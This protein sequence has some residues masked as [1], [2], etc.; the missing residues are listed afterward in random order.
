MT[1]SGASAVIAALTRAGRTLAVAE[2]LTGGALTAELV[3]VPG[4][5]AV[6]RGGVVAY[7]TALKSSL[8][9]VPLDLLAAHGPVH[10][11]VA[12]LMAEGVRDAAAVGG[13]PADIGVATTGVAGP[14]PQGDAPVGLVF[15]AVADAEGSDVRELRFTGDR[16]GIRAQAVAAAIAL[17]ADRLDDSGECRG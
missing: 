16:A 2:S 14:D 8:L 9:G 6:L 7:D 11:D 3:S 10:A 1:S 12:A 13:H 17:L 5:S 4:A 15:V